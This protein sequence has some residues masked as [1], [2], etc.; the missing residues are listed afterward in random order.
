VVENRNTLKVSEIASDQADR[1]RASPYY[2]DA[3]DKMGRQWNELVFPFIKDGNF[4]TTLEVACG[5]GRNSEYLLA[6]ADKLYLLDVNVE[7]IEFCKERFS[8][9]VLT[10]DF[11]KPG[12]Q[13][14]RKV[15]KKQLVAKNSY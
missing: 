10:H 2:D 8:G 12:K 5:H 15:L 7:N 1:W 14:L 3:E 11:A 4:L 13:V 6:L 9:T